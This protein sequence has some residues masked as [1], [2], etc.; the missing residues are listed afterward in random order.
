MAAPSRRL[1]LSPLG[2]AGRSSLPL[3]PRGRERAPRGGFVRARPLALI[4][5]AAAIGGR[6]AAETAPP[7]AAFVGARRGPRRAAIVAAGRRETPAVPGTARHR[8]HDGRPAGAPPRGP[9]SP[10]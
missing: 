9:A 8:R 3:S 6:V 2:A 5:E 10:L 1:P 7:A 4:R